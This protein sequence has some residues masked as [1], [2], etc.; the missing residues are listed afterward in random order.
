MLNGDS[1]FIPMSHQWLKVAL[2]RFPSPD[3]IAVL[4]Q[5][6]VRYVVLH[7]G[8]FRKPALLRLLSGIEAQREALLPVRDFGNDIVFEVL[9][10]GAR[11]KLGAETAHALESVPASGSIDALFDGITSEPF[12]AKETILELEVELEELTEVAGLRFHY[13]PAPRTP[14]IA[15]EV[16]FDAPVASD[17][18]TGGPGTRVAES[19]DW[20]AVAALI[21]GLIETPLNGTQTISLAPFDTTRMR[22]R[23]RGIDGR[24]PALSEIE[25]LRR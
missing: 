11:S 15:F 2:G 17:A 23:L 25:V 7:L 22:L 24:P 12:E 4:R 19:P 8:A 1:G 16:F 13:G 10:D 9:P 18:V 21:D 14:V 20:P 5:L 3:A 6:E